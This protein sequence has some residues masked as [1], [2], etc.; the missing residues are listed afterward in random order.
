LYFE[1][2][3]SFLVTFLGPKIAVSTNRRV[4]ISLPPIMISALLYGYCVILLVFTC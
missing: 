3:S 2:F 4:P 1:I